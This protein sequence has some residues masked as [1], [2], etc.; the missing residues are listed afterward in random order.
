[1]NIRNTAK[2]LLLVFTSMCYG[3]LIA[4]SCQ[5][6]AINPFEMVKRMGKGINM[7]N[8][9]EA[10]NEG[11]W[12]DPA[13]EFYFDDYKNAGFSTVRLPIR[14]DQHTATEAPYTID[15]DWLNRVEEVVDWG[16]ERDLIIIINAHHEHWFLDDYNEENLERFIAI[17]RQVAE[18]FQDKPEHLLLFEI[19]NEPYFD[20]DKPTMDFINT[21]ILNVIRTHN[22]TRNVI[23]S[24]GGANSYAVVN[25]IGLPDDEQIIATFHYYRPFSFTNGS[26]NYWGTTEDKANLVR[27]FD[28]VKVWSDEN[29]VPILLGEFGADNTVDRA[30]RLEYYRFVSEQAVQRGFAYTA[31]EQGN[32]DKG[33][34]FRSPNNWDVDVLNALVDARYWENI[35]SNSGFE[36]GKDFAWKYFVKS[37]KVTV[38]TTESTDA[39]SGD[40][41]V[42]SVVM[43]SKRLQHARIYRSFERLDPSLNTVFGAHVKGAGTAVGAKV[44]FLVN[45]RMSDN[46][47]INV[48]ELFNVG[49]TYATIGG[50]M[51]HESTLAPKKAK[52]TLQYGES[53][54][55]YLFDD[56]FIVQ[57]DDFFNTDFEEGVDFLWDETIG[58]TGTVANFSAEKVAP[59]NGYQSLKAV[60]SSVAT[61]G[62]PF[63]WQASLTNQL[64]KSVEGGNP[65]EISLMA[66]GDVGTTMATKAEYFDATGAKIGQRVHTFDMSAD[67]Q[68]YSNIYEPPLET[69]H[70]NLILM[71]GRD[72][73]TYY[74]DNVAVKCTDDLSSGKREISNNNLQ[75]PQTTLEVYPNPAQNS[76]WV[77]AISTEN[78][79]QKV[80]ITDMTGRQYQLP[81]YTQG[82][83]EGLVN[84]ESLQAGMYIIQAVSST[85]VVASKKLLIQR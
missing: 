2:L 26:V 46:S 85:G 56:F 66:K 33:F 82:F 37:T 5:Q 29:N 4:Q 35:Y 13:E 31:W 43:E 27:E 74:V 48:S 72:A 6:T 23:I 22:P 54:G 59:S 20:L 47:K 19:I 73:G 80:V 63:F 77:K 36:L 39:H 71:F 16:L 83:N 50:L 7:G 69:T 1:M 64:R 60:V 58:T 25:E 38:E 70:M 53:V 15:P 55:T 10:G 45:W 57:T 9:M 68:Q 30:D 51:S 11:W 14:W 34:Y 44:N 41:A 75:L 52:V 84:V 3:T 8:T 40:I 49:D 18:Y 12:Q 28:E 61:T 17:W 21:T 76:V 62:T 81:F 78:A 67:Y 79:L 32:G 65:Y 24:G 42:Q